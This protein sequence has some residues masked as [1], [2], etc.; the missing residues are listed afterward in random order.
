MF[1]KNNEKVSYSCIDIIVPTISSPNKSKLKPNK[2]TE[3]GCN[4]IS[5]QDCPFQNKCL[6]APKSAYQTDVTNDINE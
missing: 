1:N 2:T 6:A 4:C 5:R 3:Y